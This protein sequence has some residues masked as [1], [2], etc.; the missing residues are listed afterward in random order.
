MSRANGPGCPKR[1]WP[2]DGPQRADPSLRG[3]PCVEHIGAVC[4][5]DSARHPDGD[6][7]ARAFWRGGSGA[8]AFVDERSRGF[9]R[10]HPARAGGLALCAD[11]GHRDA[12]LC[13]RAE[14]DHHCQCGDH[15]RDC[16]LCRGG[17]WLAGAARGA[18]AG[19]D[20]CLDLGAG[21]RGDHGGLGR[22]WALAGR[23][24]GGG[25]GAGHGRDHRDRARPA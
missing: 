23:S 15:L 1:R 20:L 7:V 4:A 5:V 2:F 10:F 16:A 11:V 19:G 6:L 18:V 21:G 3:H 8:D 17:P 9:C 12:V 25:D 13:R 14:G 24:D 22:R